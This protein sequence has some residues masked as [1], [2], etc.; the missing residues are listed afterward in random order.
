MKVLSWDDFASG[1]LKEIP[2]AVT[3]G[4]FDGLHIG[5]R[6]LISRVLGQDG[7]SS[8]VFTFKVNPKRLLSPDSFPGEIS[9]LQQKLDLIASMSADVVVLIDFS[10]DFSKLPGRRFLAM[11]RDEAILRRIA[12]GVD[13][14]CGHRLDTDAEGIRSFCLECGVDMEAL[15]AVS[16]AGHPVSSSRIRKAVREGRLEDA[17]AMLA[18]HYELDLRG[19]GLGGEQVLPPP[20]RYE[21][22]LVYTGEPSVPAIVDHDGKGNWSLG[23]ASRSPDCLGLIRS[24][25]RE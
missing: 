7:L 11:L 6:Q 3:I 23:G 18:R 2:L 5:H 1:A 21:A 20:G 15:S 12:V 10:G 17:Q 13:F 8:A 9:T 4:V 22:S 25:S 14:R 19:H 16:W 24:V